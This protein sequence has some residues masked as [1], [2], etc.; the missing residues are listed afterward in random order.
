MLGRR[1]PGLFP[2]PF[3]LLTLRGDNLPR[4]DL[5][6][7]DLNNDLPSQPGRILNQMQLWLAA[8]V[9]HRVQPV[10]PLEP[11]GRLVLI[12]R[13]GNLPDAGTA[14][15]LDEPD[16]DR[17]RGVFGMRPARDQVEAAVLGLDTLDPACPAL[18]RGE[19]R[20][21]PRSARCRRPRPSARVGAWRGRDGA[22]PRPGPGERCRRWCS[23]APLELQEPVLEPV[24]EPVEMDLGLGDQAVEARDRLPLDLA[25]EQVGK[26]PVLAVDRA[27]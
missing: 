9:K 13:Q 16:L 5:V 12:G 3:G 18:P 10:V 19:S 20:T 8:A 11:L 14:L 17:G 26:L 21:R 23:A 27:H 22:G 24:V 25:V 7:L 4:V 15:D 6:M 2:R 1:R